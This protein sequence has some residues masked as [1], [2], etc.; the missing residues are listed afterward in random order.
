MKLK[1]ERG[2]QGN[3][4]VGAGVGWEV[5]PAGGIGDT[6]APLLS[7]RDMGPSRSLNTVCAHH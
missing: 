4:G 1:T 2:K 5:G 7:E 3:G 6:K